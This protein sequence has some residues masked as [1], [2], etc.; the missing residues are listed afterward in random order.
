M[1][2][3]VIPDSKNITLTN[4]MQVST[5]IKLAASIATAKNT[6]PE[7]MRELKTTNFAKKPEKGGIPLAANKE[8]IIASAAGKFA[9]PSELSVKS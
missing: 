7:V 5:D 2:F 8:A 3:F 4:L 9:L 6:S 1:L